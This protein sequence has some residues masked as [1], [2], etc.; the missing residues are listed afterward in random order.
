MVRS[1]KKSL[2][3]QRAEEEKP[4]R[5]EREELAEVR[6]ELGLDVESRA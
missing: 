5:L 4:E 3:P 6:A 2:A 1:A